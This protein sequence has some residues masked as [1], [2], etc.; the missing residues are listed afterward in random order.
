MQILD[1]LWN[2]LAL[3]AGRCL[4]NGDG[5]DTC[6]AEAQVVWN[7]MDST[8]QEELLAFLLCKETKDLQNERVM[9]QL[10]E[11]CKEHFKHSREAHVVRP[12]CH[13]LGYLSH[14]DVDFLATP[15]GGL[16][17]KIDGGHVGSLNLTNA[18]AI[19]RGT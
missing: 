12:L 9:F 8:L 1:T 13:L 16:G 14:A 5:L 7:L 18:S 3:E 15:R 4:N 6:S 2:D 11:L 17:H 19:N 10:E